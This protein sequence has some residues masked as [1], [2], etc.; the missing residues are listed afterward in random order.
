MYLNA[1]SPNGHL[2]NIYDRIIFYSYKLLLAELFKSQQ[3]NDSTN[4]QIFYKCCGRLESPS[5]GAR[6]RPT[7]TAY[8]QFFK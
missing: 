1:F 5:S 6:R 8:G 3:P 7:L 4:N 2:L